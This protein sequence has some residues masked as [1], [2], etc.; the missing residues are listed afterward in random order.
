M[1]LFWLFFNAFDFISDSLSFSFLLLHSALLALF[2][3]KVNFFV[4]SFVELLPVRLFLFLMRFSS[5]LFLSKFMD[6]WLVLAKWR[7]QLRKSRKWISPRSLK[8]VLTSG[9]FSIG[10]FRSLLFLILFPSSS[11]FLF[12]AIFL[13]SGSL[14]VFFSFRELVLCFHGFLLCSLL[15]LSC[16]VYLILE[17]LWLAQAKEKD[18]TQTRRHKQTAQQESSWVKCW[19]WGLFGFLDFRRLCSLSIHSWLQR[20]KVQSVCLVW[21]ATCFEDDTLSLFLLCLSCSR[22]ACFLLLGM[23]LGTIKFLFMFGLS[24]SI[25]S[26]SHFSFSSSP[27]PSWA[28]VTGINCCSDRNEGTQERRERCMA[29]RSRGNT[30][31]LRGKNWAKSIVQHEGTMSDLRVLVCRWSWRWRWWEEWRIRGSIWND[32]KCDDELLAFLIKFC[33]GARLVDQLRKG[34]LTNK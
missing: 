15:S 12:L 28:F 1:V 8:A 13:P 24:L 3:E 34:A 26:F 10:D 7:A 31:R 29:S 19:Q 23:L 33:L 32:G 18:P 2:R 14:V 30:A 22:I 27:P 20:E 25:P 17:M 6:L 21:N 9:F 4:L 5:V 16:F 11:P